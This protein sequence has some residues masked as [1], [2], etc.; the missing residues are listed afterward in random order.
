MPRDRS[1]AVEHCSFGAGPQATHDPAAGD[2]AMN[3]GNDE[4]MNEGDRQGFDI[5]INRSV[6]AEEVDS[7]VV[8]A[9]FGGRG[10]MTVGQ[11]V[12]K[13]A[14]TVGLILHHLSDDTDFNWSGIM[15]VMSGCGLNKIPSGNKA[16]TLF[17]AF[18]SRHL[19][20]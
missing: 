13:R 20:I 9:V 15:P 7:P 1:V 2:E 17:G 4:S 14:M 11:L 8:S 5:V 12:E 6:Y 19:S 10:R 18:S 3:E 16:S